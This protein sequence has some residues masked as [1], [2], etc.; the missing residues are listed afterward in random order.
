MFWLINSTST[1][2][3]TETANHFDPAFDSIPAV[4]FVQSW[5]LNCGYLIHL[6]QTIW[7]ASY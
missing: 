1:P 2:Q 3:H 4:H 7:S 6:I 5:L